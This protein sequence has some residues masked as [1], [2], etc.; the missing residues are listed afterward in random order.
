MVDV[1][2]NAVCSRCAIVDVEMGCLRRM[3]RS[4]CRKASNA[5]QAECLAKQA[6]ATEE[7]H[8]HVPLSITM[9]TFTPSIRGRLDHFVTREPRV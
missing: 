8:S 6:K 4:D 9:A 7:S 1:G 3:S 2:G 5:T